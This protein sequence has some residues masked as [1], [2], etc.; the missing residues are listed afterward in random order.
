MR[1]KPVW[2][3]L[4]GAMLLSACSGQQNTEDAAEAD[5]TFESAEAAAEAAVDAAAATDATD[6]ADA[7]RPPKDPENPLPEPDC[8]TKDEGDPEC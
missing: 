8:A 7:A 4:G 6:A 5:A 1:L 2:G 3:I